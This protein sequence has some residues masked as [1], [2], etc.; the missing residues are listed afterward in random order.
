MKICKAGEIKDIVKGEISCIK[1]DSKKGERL[2]FLINMCD[3]YPNIS[4]KCV[5]INKLHRGTFHN[6]KKNMKRFII[7]FSTLIV[8]NL[9]IILILSNE[10]IRDK[11]SSYIYSKI[12]MANKDVQQMGNIVKKFGRIYEFVKNYSMIAAPIFLLGNQEEVLNVIDKND[13]SSTEEL[14]SMPGA[15]NNNWN[16]PS[17][18]KL[19]FNQ[20]KKIVDELFKKS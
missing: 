11:L 2:K 10:N 18:V 1:A 14:L 15:W 12:I 16:T 8:Y 6:I 5:E 13:N 19:S 7:P 4:E 9:I 17:P 20:S 3:K